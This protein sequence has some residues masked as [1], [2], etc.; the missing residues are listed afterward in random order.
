MRQQ[1]CFYCKII[2]LSGL[3]ENLNCAFVLNIGKFLLYYYVNSY[4]IFYGVKHSIKK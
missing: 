2:I 4:I 1:L 3:Y